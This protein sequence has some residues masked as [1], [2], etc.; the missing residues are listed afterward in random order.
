MQFV[1]RSLRSAGVVGDDENDAA[2]AS[3]AAAGGD[4]AESMSPQQVPGQSPQQQISPPSAPSPLALPPAP[5]PSPQQQQQ[6]PDSDGGG[7]SDWCLPH[8][9]DDCAQ[10]PNLLF[11]CLSVANG[12]LKNAF[13]IVQFNQFQ[14]IIAVYT[15]QAPTDTCKVRPRVSSTSRF[16]V[17]RII[18]TFGHKRISQLWGQ[19][20]FAR[21]YIPEKINKMPE[22]YMI[23]A[24]KIYFSRIW[25]RG[26]SA[27]LHP[28]LIRLCFR[29]L[30]C[31]FLVAKIHGSGFKSSPRKKTSKWVPF[32]RK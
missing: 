18:V 4:S 26:A 23:F 29:F 25:G 11:G 15:L 21:K 1:E 5:A 9:V 27:P 32:C 3:V 14:Q 8:F 2:A 17:C 24:R 22:F 13:V 16:S 19:D 20:I 7:V 10:R 6:S 12:V 28:R 31:R 30:L